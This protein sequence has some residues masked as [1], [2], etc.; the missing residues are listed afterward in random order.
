MT[1]RQ[2][3]LPRGVVVN[4]T[5]IVEIQ[6]KTLTVSRHGVR[7]SPEFVCFKLKNQPAKYGRANEA[8]LKVLKGAVLGGYDVVINPQDQLLKSADWFIAECRKRMSA[9]ASAS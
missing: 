8:F 9:A 2:L 4:W 3:S 5:D 1:Q 6:K 7:H